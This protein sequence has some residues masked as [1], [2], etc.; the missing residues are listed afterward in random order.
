MT[1]PDALLASVA[2]AGRTLVFCDESDLTIGATST[3][4][5][6]IHAWVGLEMPSDAYSALSSAVRWYQASH[7]VPE[8]HGNEIVNAGSKS[9][10]R[11]Q[12]FERRLDAFRF[13]CNLVVE[14]AA[15]L[16]TVHIPAEQYQNWVDEGRCRPDSHKDGVKEVFAK[17]IV[18]HLADRAPA[19]LIFDKHKNNPG[20]TL[21]PVANAPHLA[22]GGILLADSNAVAGLQIAD[23][24]AYAIGR[25]LKRRDRLLDDTANAFD[26][27][28][29]KMLEDLPRPVRS[30]LG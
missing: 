16:L 13:A 21:L 28:A 10:W 29:A 8:F 30:L 12:S 26:R 25:Y 3:M 4:C 18:E 5:A 11:P 23:V 17:S 9:A 7:R 1:T 27:V 22:G 19:L 15:L 2:D 20:P 14:H 24:A 6:K